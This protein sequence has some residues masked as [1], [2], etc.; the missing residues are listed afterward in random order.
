M[1]STQPKE[2]PGCGS[3]VPESD[4]RT[5]P[6]CGSLKCEKCDMGDGVAGFGDSPEAAM[7]DF[8]QAW[9]KKLEAGR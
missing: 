6:W 7:R 5:C 4:L 8:D 1:S 9:G 2:C 3:P